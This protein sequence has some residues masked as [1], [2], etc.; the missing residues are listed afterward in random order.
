M[1][2]CRCWQELLY[3]RVVHLDGGVRHDIS[4]RFHF[5]LEV[6]QLLVDHRAENPLQI[7]LRRERHVDQVEA[8]L[9]TPGNHHP[10]TA[11]GTHSA[12]EEHAG[13]PFH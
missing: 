10:T 4:D 1:D 2:S 7:R 8:R 11:G 6:L 5:L 9:Q 3:N 13:D 12:Q